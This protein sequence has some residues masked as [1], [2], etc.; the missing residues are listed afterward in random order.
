MVNSTIIKMLAQKVETMER[1]ID[2]YIV[3][4]GTILDIV[5][6]VSD[7]SAKLVKLEG[8]VKHIAK[9]FHKAKSKSYADNDAFE[10]YENLNSILLECKDDHRKVSNI[11][12]DNGMKI[13]SFEDYKNMSLPSSEDSG[14]STFEPMESDSTSISQIDGDDEKTEEGVEMRESGTSFS[15]ED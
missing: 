8:K 15:K 13:N 6:E 7:V 1:T 5:G 11:S 14:L 4:E 12:E 2:F 9:R 10:N 3:R